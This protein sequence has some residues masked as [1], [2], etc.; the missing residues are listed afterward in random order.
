MRLRQNNTNLQ[1]T[2]LPGGIEGKS[3]EDMK[4]KIRM[5]AQV[6]LTMIFA[7]VLFSWA[8]KPSS[9]FDEYVEYGRYRDITEYVSAEHRLEI[10]TVEDWLNFA[11]RVS[12]GESFYDWVITLRSDLDFAGYKD[13]TPIGSKEMPFQGC[14][15][16]N[17]HT[18]Y[19]VFMESD[20]DY[21]GVFG[22]A[23]SPFI[24]GL[25]LENC[26]LSS[27]SARGTGGIVGYAATGTIQYCSFQGTI[28]A[29]E[30][31]AGGIVGDNWA[32][33]HSCVSYGQIQ[34][35]SETAYYVLPY[36][37]KISY[38]TGGIAGDNVGFIGR[39]I[40]HA[41][42]FSNAEPNNVGDGQG[43]IVGQNC[44]NIESCANFGSARSGIADSNKGGIRGCINTGDVAAGI[45]YYTDYG[46]QYCVNLGQT[47]GRYAA[48]I[49]SFCGNNLLE[50]DYGMISECL[51]IGA[52]DTGV[53]RENRW[54]ESVI[55][56]IFRI[57]SLSTEE[58]EQV[59]D[60]VETSDYPGAFR[61]LVET[62]H[63][64]RTT[65]ARW[66]LF[67]Y[68]QLLL[69]ANVFLLYGKKL[70]QYPKYRH[71][72]KQ[73]H[74][75]QYQQACELFAQA[76]AIDDASVLEAQCLAAYLRECAPKELFE[77]GRIDG[78]RIPWRLIGETDNTW[79]L[80]SEFALITECVHSESV[81]I[82]W[83]N[84]TLCQKLNESCKEVWFSKGEVALLEKELSILSLSDVYRLFSHSEDRKCQ[85]FSRLD[86][87]LSGGGYIYWWVRRDDSEPARK[88]PF[89]TSEGLVSEIGKFATADNIAVRPVMEVRKPQ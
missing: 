31:S 62:A 33:I 71:G 5:I 27:N 88:M 74:Q 59:Q 53:I 30:G 45:S 9:C 20:V 61:F 67:V 28:R 13:L 65:I 22:Y 34:G 48:D 75:G 19:N 3:G 55:D 63:R 16:G 79:V 76:P 56:N 39:C 72:K 49:A 54:R 10:Y 7:A 84:S 17:G 69:T 57:R 46:L 44:S 82:C 41:T 58:A 73:M 51:Y 32:N 42:V 86:H 66:M 26:M 87:V 78:K 1:K 21:V 68:V 47:S 81:P 36:G 8:M 77:I 83:E 4:D 24:S 6:V 15:Q 50:S 18:L 52:S 85:P 35:T 43:G 37:M 2:K 70:S 40:N 89:V 38:S 12:E 29:E 14:F 64:Q 23:E 25:H 60:Y 11:E 80:L